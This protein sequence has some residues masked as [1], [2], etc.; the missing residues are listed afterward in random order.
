MVLMVTDDVAQAKALR[1]GFSAWTRANPKLARFEHAHRSRHRDFG[2]CRRF[3]VDGAALLIWLR[4]L[5]QVADR[6]PP[7]SGVTLI[8]LVFKG[9]FALTSPLWTGVAVLIIIMFAGWE[10]LAR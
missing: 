7:D 10:A 1:V 8:G 4:L 6:R 9:L 5:R 2:D 3:V